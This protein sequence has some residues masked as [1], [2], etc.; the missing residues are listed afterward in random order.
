MLDIILNYDDK[1]SLNTQGNGAFTESGGPVI[2]NSNNP[3]A[4]LDTGRGTIKGQEFDITGGIQLGGNGSLVTQPVAGR[5]VDRS[6]QRGS[7]LA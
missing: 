7:R 2:V 3:S 6:G 5:H 4:V 1:A